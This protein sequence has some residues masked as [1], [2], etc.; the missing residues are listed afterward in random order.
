[1]AI[2]RLNTKYVVPKHNERCRK[3][4]EIITIMLKKIYGSIETNYNPQVG[5]KPGDFIGLACA[6]ELWEIF[7]A[8]QNHRGYKEFVRV[9]KL[10]RCD[11]F[12]PDPGFIVEFDESQH[13]TSARKLSL[14]HYPNSLKIGFSKQTWIDL[15]D[16]IQAR[17]NDPYFRDEQRAWYDTLRDYMSEIKGFGPTV[18]LYSKEMLW[19]GLDPNSSDDISRFQELIEDRQGGA[20]R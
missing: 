14:L 5:T 16:E 9:K 3:C 6:S 18:R 2:D 17:D 4:K 11:F 10:W 12:V 15:C 13:F 7:Q 19:C 20:R 1:M 8:L